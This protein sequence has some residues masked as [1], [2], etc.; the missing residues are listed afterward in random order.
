M[1]EQ[2]CSL[3]SSWVAEKRREGG[4]ENE[5]EKGKNWGQ[6]RYSPQEHAPKD[7]LTS[8]KFHFICCHYLPVGSC[9]IDP[10]MILLIILE[11]S[12]FN[13]FPKVPP[14]NTWSKLLT[15]KSLGEISDPIE[16]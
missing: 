13:H 3:D 4:R 8:T 5:N 2:T 11:T 15:H 6:K 7:P 16:R 14:L 10:S 9:F 1:V 12:C